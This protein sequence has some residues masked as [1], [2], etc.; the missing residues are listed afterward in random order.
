MNASRKFTISPTLLQSI[1]DESW[2]MMIERIM[3]VIEV[4]VD[5]AYADKFVA[6]D[7]QFLRH[8]DGNVH[9]LHRQYEQLSGEWAYDRQ[10]MAL[11]AGL[12][13]GRQFTHLSSSVLGNNSERTVNK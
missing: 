8:P 9:M 1:V 3:N 10:R 12:L 11:Q 2:S 6:L 5:G 4:Q 7:T 13:I